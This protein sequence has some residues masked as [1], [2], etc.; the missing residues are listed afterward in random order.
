[1]ATT[2]ATSSTIRLDLPDGLVVDATTDAGNAL[3]DRFFALYDLAFILPSEKEQRSGFVDC[4]ALNHGTAHARLAA[5]W[6]PFREWVLL[7]RDAGAGDNVVGG[8]NFI[9][10]ALP[11]PGEPALPAMHLNYIFVEPAHRRRGYLARIIRACQ[12]LARR[13]LEAPAGRTAPALLTFIEQNDPLRLSSDDYA[14]DSAQAGIDQIDR[15]RIWQRAGA[16][17]IDF[18]YVQPA[19][20]DDQLPDTGLLLSVIGAPGDALDPC[21]LKR[22]LERFFAISVLKERDLASDGVAQRQL[23]LCDEARRAGKSLALFDA[24][25]W[26]DGLGAARPAGDGSPARLI[27]VLRASSA[28]PGA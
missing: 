15:V 25:R 6:G 10:F 1:M 7:V 19:L 24:G 5:A 9:C 8:A 21:M 26:L 16:R 17:I 11:V 27:D 2:R 20:S 12:E 13:T 23:A 3:F 18:P 22:H 14:R 4:L 28:V